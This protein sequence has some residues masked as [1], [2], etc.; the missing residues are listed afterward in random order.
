MAKL[1]EDSITSLGDRY[2]AFEEN[3]D[4][5]QNP[6]GN[7]FFSITHLYH[8]MTL[9]DAQIYVFEERGKIDARS[10][11]YYHDAIKRGHIH[12]EQ[13]ALFTLKL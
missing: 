3:G 1:V 6:I 7:H 5:D 4:K 12:P 10:Y 13:S 9:S 2:W 11:Y 8:N